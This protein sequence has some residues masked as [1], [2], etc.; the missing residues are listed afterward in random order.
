MPRAGLP[1]EVADEILKLVKDDTET[2]LSC[3]RASKGL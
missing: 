3:C 2:L 1:P